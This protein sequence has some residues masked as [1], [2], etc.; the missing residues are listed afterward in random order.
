LPL[1]RLSAV[2][3]EQAANNASKHDKRAAATVMES[4]KNA[5]RQSVGKCVVA[6]I[7]KRRVCGGRNWLT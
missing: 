2:L 5:G 6:I 7:L 4:Y 1:L 3:A